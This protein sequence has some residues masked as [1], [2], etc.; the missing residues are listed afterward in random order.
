MIDFGHLSYESGRGELLCRPQLAD[1]FLAWFAWKT[2]DSFGEMNF[3]DVPKAI[4]ENYSI[5]HRACMEYVKATFE[6]VSKAVYRLNEKQ[7]AILREVEEF[8]SL[9]Q[10]LRESATNVI[11]EVLS[12]G[13]DKLRLCAAISCLHQSCADG[14]WRDVDYQILYFVHLLNEQEDIEKTSKAI[15]SI[16]EQQKK[17]S[18]KAIIHKTYFLRAIPFPAYKTLCDLLFLG[19]EKLSDLFFLEGDDFLPL[20]QSLSE[21]PETL[22]KKVLDGLFVKKGEK[23]ETFAYVFK[24]RYGIGNGL[25]QM[26]LEEVAKELGVTRERIRQIGVRVEA[27]LASIADKVL[28][29]GFMIFSSNKPDFSAIGYEEAI[30]W[31]KD[32]SVCDALALAASKNTSFLCYD[33][34]LGCFYDPSWTNPESIVDTILMRQDEFIKA[35]DFDAMSGLEKRAILTEYSLRDVGYYVKRSVNTSRMV[36]SIMERFFQDGYGNYDEED[37]KDLCSILAREY[38]PEY[39]LPSQQAMRGLVMR[40]D[41]FCQIDRG[42][43]IPR[44]L[45]VIPDMVF[46]MSI[47]DFLNSQGGAV[48]YRTIY[49]KFKDEFE[50]MGVGNHFYAK[51]IIDPYLR[52]Y[53]FHTKRD[54]VIPEG[55]NETAW[56][57][58]HR[59]LMEQEGEF[60]FQDIRN[61]FPGVQDY[62]FQFQL[63]DTPE[64]LNLGG[65]HYVHFSKCGITEEGK[66]LIEEEIESSLDASDGFVTCHRVWTNLYLFHPGFESEM[67]AVRGS[68]A[69]FSYILARE[70]FRDK[71]ELRRPYILRKGATKPTEATFLEHFMGK[72]S[73]TIKECAQYRDKLGISGCNWSFISF[74]ESLCDNFVLVDRYEA[75]RTDAFPITEKELSSVRNTLLKI[76]RT[77]G[78]F[79]SS[80]EAGLSMLPEAVGGVEMSP[81]LLL[82][83]VWTYLQDAFVAEVDKAIGTGMKYVIKEAK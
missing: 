6:P 78:E 48:Y 76:V 18:L 83:I 54:Y 23:N 58:V 21:D 3:R 20:F 60:S 74:V 44:S 5:N 62:V 51:G 15:A 72:R 55:S 73:F 64:L 63:Y 33:E 59:F 31:F 29:L 8:A 42:L 80:D 41:Y 30:K 10:E 22:I 28:P 26:T 71:Y 79:S 14:S 39:P 2:V 36:M 43:H 57:A 46:M 70:D 32:P 12:G 24:K 75:R 34:K 56:D 35:K 19:A 25:N 53:G 1:A 37:Y 50:A 67:G 9:R 11:A 82:G 7:Q 69:L 47:V 16:P 45:T 81:S 77:R 38:G 4:S 65:K 49:E 17:Q 13:R 66:R 52:D 40:E 61:H 68:F 27:E